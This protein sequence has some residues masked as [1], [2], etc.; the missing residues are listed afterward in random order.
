MKGRD[1]LATYSWTAVDGRPKFTQIRENVCEHQLQY[2]WDCFRSVHMQPNEGVQSNGHH[3]HILKLRL[4]V[5]NR[6]VPTL[7]ANIAS[8]LTSERCRSKGRSRSTECSEDGCLG[9]HGR[10]YHGTSPILEQSSSQ[11]Y[12]SSHCTTYL[13]IPRPAYV[14][15]RRPGTCS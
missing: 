11:D 3:S 15:V 9:E 1:L 5:T 6:H 4:Y 7:I 14:F 10:L 8:I 2:D 13:G 12:H